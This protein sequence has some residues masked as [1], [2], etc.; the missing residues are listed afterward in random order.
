MI[1]NVLVAHAKEAGLEAVPEPA[2]YDLLLGQFSAKDCKRVFPKRMSAAS[3]TAY[4]ALE[5]ASNF[6][7]SASCTF[8]PEEKQAFIQNHLDK[9]PL[10]E[11][12]VGLRIDASFRNPETDEVLWIDTSVVHT[13]APSYIKAELKSIVKRK[14]CEDA[15]KQYMLPHAQHNDSSPAMLHRETDKVKKYSRLVTVAKKQKVD[16]TRTSVPTFY[17]FVVSSCGEL[18]PK[19]YEVQEWLVIQYKRKCVKEGRRRDGRTTTELV[20][21]FRHRLKM[22]VQTAAAVGIGL[23]IQNAGVAWRGLGPA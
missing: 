20:R 7:T 14:L 2:T 18:A 17:P 13:S 1:R 10:V 23:M 8:T 6:I 11:D 16:G 15:S 19:A 4:D 3:Q 21:D 9:L 22:A 5:R 12:Q